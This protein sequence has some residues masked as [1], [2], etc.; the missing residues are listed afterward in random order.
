M[1]K[2]Y[3]RA[4]RL[5]NLKRLGKSDKEK[6]WF[7]IYLLIY[8]FMIAN[9]WGDRSRNENI[10][11]YMAVIVPIVFVFF[12]EII[13]PVRLPKIMYLCP[14]T[15]DSRREM[16][17]K[18]YYF[19]VCLHWG[20]QLLGLLAV[21]IYIGYD[22]VIMPEYAVNSLLLSM[23][24][25]TEKKY[26]KGYQDVVKI[27]AIFLNVIMASSLIDRDDSL[28]LKLVMLA[29]FLVVQLPFMRLSWIYIRS[30]LEN[31]VNYEAQEGVR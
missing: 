30:E 18:S 12:S 10:L 11:L 22:P 21:N 19:R 1:W 2:E 17:R 8:P 27:V 3:W 25:S 15:D 13:H 29:V 16:I 23:L 5:N 7:V 14:M 9:N 20:V 6:L 26:G 24:I 31:A 4:F 28:I